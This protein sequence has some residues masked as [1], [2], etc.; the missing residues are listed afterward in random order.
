[1]ILV[2]KDNAQLITQET[3]RLAEDKALEYLIKAGLKFVARNYS[4]HTGEVDLIMRDKEFLVFI[5]VRSRKSER[6]GGGVG[7]ITYA[8]RQ[9]IIKTTSH[10]II[11]HKVS[12]KY[13]TRFDVISIDGALGTISWIKDAF[14]TDY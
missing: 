11:K 5:E 4:C 2:I 9:K 14:G 3:G 1:M 10:Y 8:K 7:S 6:F 13:S 12:D